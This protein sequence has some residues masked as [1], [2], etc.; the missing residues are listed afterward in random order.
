MAAPVLDLLIDGADPII[1]DRSFGTTPAEVV[2]LATAFIDG[3]QRCGITAV[4]K[5]IPGMGRV[6]K[7]SQTNAVISTPV[8]V[9]REL[10][11]VT[12]RLVT[13]SLGNDGTCRHTRVG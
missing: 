4:V 3:L 5:H 7:D 2:P 8:S 11:W 12:F 1:G 6:D 13:E 10:D 9:L